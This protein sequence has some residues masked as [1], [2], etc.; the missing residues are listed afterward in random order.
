MNDFINIKI[1]KEKEFLKIFFLPKEKVDK[2]RNNFYTVIDG[3]EIESV[4]SPQIDISSKKIY[5]NGRNKS[6]DYNY[7]L[8]ILFSE[9]LD[10]IIKI[11]V[12]LDNYL[13]KI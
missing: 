6:Y 11:L 12:K 3:W 4:M 7:A 9:R 2:I 13:S 8:K 10:E 1:K 5:I